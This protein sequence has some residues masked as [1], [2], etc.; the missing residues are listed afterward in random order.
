M[1]IPVLLF[2]FLNFQSVKREEEKESTVEKVK[3]KEK[4]EV[5]TFVSLKMD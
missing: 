4:K 5:V 1:M 3:Q 2:L